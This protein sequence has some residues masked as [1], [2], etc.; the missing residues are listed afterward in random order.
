MLD[1]FWNLYQHRQISELRQDAIRAKYAENPRDRQ[2]SELE[3]RVDLL[4]LTNM[5]IWSLISGRL[6]LSDADLQAEMRRLD[7]ADGVEDG[8]INQ[9]RT[10]PDCGR[11]V[12]RRVSRCIYCGT[13]VGATL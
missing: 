3:R 5:A 7:L 1:F 6:G 12:A 10:C 13:D 2:L 8:K 11:T 4:A 9:P